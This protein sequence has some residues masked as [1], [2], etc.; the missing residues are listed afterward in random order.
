MSSS[1]NQL[2]VLLI[3]EDLYA[4]IGGGQTVYQNFVRNNPQIDFFYFDSGKKKKSSPKNAFSIKLGP[5][6]TIDIPS[7]QKNSL[8]GHIDTDLLN[9]PITYGAIAKSWRYSLALKNLEFDLIEIP[10][11]QVLGPLI[12]E[13][14]AINNVKY[15][16]LTLFLH[17]SISSSYK[18]SKDMHYS[19]IEIKVLEILEKYTLDAADAIF[20]ISPSYFKEMNLPNTRTFF[21]SPFACIEKRKIDRMTPRKPKELSA[22]NFIGRFEERKG[23]KFTILLAPMT[24]NVFD[25]VRIIGPDAK[26]DF[27]F[28]PLTE[29]S[30]NRGVETR[31]IDTSKV[32]R[33]WT[34]IKNN[35]LVLIP[36]IF[37]SFNLVAL[38]SI[39]RGYLT[40]ISS[41]CGANSYLRDA[42]PEIFFLDLHLT[43]LEGFAS[44]L[45]KTQTDL[46][47]NR[48]LYRNQVKVNELIERER[49]SYGE[50][51]KEVLRASNFVNHSTWNSIKVEMKLPHRRITIAKISSRIRKKIRKKI[52]KGGLAL[53]IY[54]V[55]NAVLK[56]FQFL[57]LIRREPSLKK[58]DLFSFQ[59]KNPFVKL[60]IYKKS[61]NESLFDLVTLSYAM[62]YAKFLGYEVPEPLRDRLVDALSDFEMHEEATVFKLLSSKDN[63]FNITAYLQDRLERLRINPSLNVK[64]VKTKSFS[65]R[66]TECSI[67]VSMYNGSGKVVDFIERIR[68]CPEIV[69][70]KAELVFIDA[71]SESWDCDSAIEFMHRYSISGKV[72]RTKDRVSI[73]EAWNIG[74]SE[75]KGDY[76]MFLG[77]DEKIYPDAISILLSSL[78]EN[79]ATDWV[80]GNTVVTKVD[81]NGVHISDV[82][83]YN[84]TN[85]DPVDPILETC[86]LSWVGG[87]YRK[88]IHKRFGYYD[89][90][91]KGAG[92]TEFKNRV[93]GFLKILYIDCTTGEFLDF[94]EE[95]VTATPKIEIEDLRAWH[96]FRT[97]GGLDYWERNGFTNIRSLIQS[98]SE[99]YRK[100]YLRDF[101]S[102][103]TLNETARNHQRNDFISLLKGFLD[104]NGSI[105][106]SIIGLYRIRKYVS[107][108]PA[109]D[110]LF[111]IDKMKKDNIFEQYNGFW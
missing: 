31:L 47:T 105:T 78:K 29:M 22:L 33:P 91:F 107:S 15:R 69:E 54:I 39:Q 10:E 20:Y 99:K 66:K 11:F 57:T 109:R 43:N 106:R 4:D 35:D 36:S 7:L 51:V 5:W 67:I 59:P 74:I 44:E 65:G 94:P 56:I 55:I 37:D 28:E 34:Y 72:L 111:W 97:Q 12:R 58:E 8:T 13:F 87:M 79:P 9:H 83:K 62:R 101:S 41:G 17:G 27:V 102:D 50:S 53:R 61:A 104:S 1:Q 84:R 88:S 3:I 93:L 108:K 45:V 77:L 82:M 70:G 100:S 76:L 52:E 73:Q 42:Y 48:L 63:E 49:N 16:K 71:N 19:E 95:R 89:P 90:S 2:K 98:K 23:A 60:L 68:H 86:Y 38:E 40:G 30:R 25:S 85:A 75:A 92:D 64:M 32:N 6:P 81:K 110:S 103:W 18:A 26:D 24:R 21:I 46:E 80:M 96:I 14:L